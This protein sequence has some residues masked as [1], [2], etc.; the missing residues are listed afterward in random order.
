MNGS[1]FQAGH[2]AKPGAGNLWPFVLET[3]PSNCRRR[4]HLSRSPRRGA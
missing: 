4:T 1:S 3:T 2:I